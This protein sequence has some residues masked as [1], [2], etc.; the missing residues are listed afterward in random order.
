M[1]QLVTITSKLYD[2]SG[3]YVINLKVKSRYKGSSRENINKTDQ[4]GLFIFHASPNRTVEILAQP[5]NTKDYIVVKTI[6]SS[7]V[8]SRKDP[9][10]VP[11]PKS[12]EQY[13]QKKVTTTSKG[14]VT[15]LF[16]IIDSKEK[17]L[18]NFPVTSRPKGSQK[19]FERNS[20]EQGIVEV[21]SSP[22]RDIEILV[23]TSN[24]EFTL[25]SSVNSGN[26]S[27]I[28]IIIK[29]D[30]P[31]E[32]FKSLSNFKIVDRL[33]NDY[34]IENTKIEILYLESGIKK[35]SNTS[36][37]KFSL[38]SMVGEKVKITV[39]KPDG[40][41]LEANNYYSKRMKEDSN[42]LELDVDITEG[43]T[44]PNEPIINKNIKKICPP[45]CVVET[46]TFE[47]SLGEMIIS[48]QALDAILKWEKYE[49]KP[50]V[51]SKGQDGKSGV[52]LGYGYDLGHQ[53]GDQI[54]KDLASYYTSSQIQRLLKAQGKKGIAAQKLVDSFSDI[55]ITKD[56]A[57]QM[58]MIVKK[59]YA[60]DT[61]KVYPDILKY[62]PHCQG[63]ILSLVYNRYIG[64]KGDRRKE[65]KEIQDDLKSK[66]KK[67]PSLLR[68]MK[69]LW[70]TKANRGL[71]ARREEEAK[72]FEKGL[73]C[74]C[75]K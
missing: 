16:K 22:N 58:V 43:S 4:D 75:Y 28:S 13:Q 72:I 8:S 26:G 17:I 61:L 6:N 68:S 49:S 7:I 60:E 45:E 15:T 40:K 35:V 21:L 24:D 1:S 62:H 71:Q 20:N 54:K 73:K 11:L 18:I 3:K 42:K 55:T 51:P 31:Y 9:V 34:N 50:Y 37:G 52:T 57:Y 63:A 30:E 59:R 29:L 33:G 10:K 36:N 12:I 5:P 65:M 69:R 53:S 23:L 70:T 32:N 19:S 27:Q 38:Q 25:K 39:F 56:K 74:E 14:I 2:A 66:G 46:Y 44:R 48:K 47:T 64:L 67:V 41:P